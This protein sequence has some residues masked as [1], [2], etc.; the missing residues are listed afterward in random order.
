MLRR[1]TL[2]YGEQDLDIVTEISHDS[3]DGMKTVIPYNPSWAQ[4]F[5]QV[6]GGI[7]SALLLYLACKSFKE[8]RAKVRIVPVSIEVPTKAKS[9]GSARAVIGKVRELV[10]Y[11]YLGPGL[12]YHIPPEQCKNPHKD[13]FFNQTLARL[14]ENFP[15]SFEMN[16]N[17]KNPPEHVRV[18]FPNDEFRQKVRDSRTTIYNTPKSASPHAMNDKSGIVALYHKEG[19]VDDLAPLTLSCDM[20]RAEIERR[21]LGLPCGHCWWCHE[22]AWGF[23]SN[24]LTDPSF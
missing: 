23:S 6:S 7:D 5:I 2:H 16:G 17:T 12:E 13:M 4:I 19:I 15:N 1:P 22:R 18:G 3:R 24:N 9:L 21:S 20:D 8:I 11:E 10:G 14:L